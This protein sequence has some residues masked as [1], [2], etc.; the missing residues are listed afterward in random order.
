MEENPQ[1]FKFLGNCAKI[2]EKLQEEKL[3]QNPQI[4][5]HVQ[6]K[7]Y[8]HLLSEIENFVRVQVNKSEST[9]FLDISG[10]QF[11]FKKL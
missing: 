11:I 3:F 9:I 10:T 1:V 7:E 5:L 6:P 2:A 4:T 8:L